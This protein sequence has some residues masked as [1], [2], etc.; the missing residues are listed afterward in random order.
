LPTDI[1]ASLAP[2]DF[3]RMVSIGV[4]QLA[5]E[6]EELLV[7]I[8]QENLPLRLRARPNIKLQ[9]DRA[10]EPGCVVVEALCNEG[11]V[12]DTVEVAQ[13]ANAAA[14]FLEVFFDGHRRVYGLAT[15]TL[16]GQSPTDTVRI[17]HPS[18]SREHARI[19]VGADA[20]QMQDLGAVNRVSVNG[21]RVT[22]VGPLSAGASIRPSRDVM[23]LLC[24]DD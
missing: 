17:D 10:V 15:R 4:E 3:D 6:T 16:I 11:A 19:V 18:V 5:R 2:G 22:D 1:T 13:N 23:A 7:R 24:S 8:E 12:M 20:L 14:L 21:E 9:A